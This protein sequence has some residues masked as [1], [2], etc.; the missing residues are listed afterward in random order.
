MLIAGLAPGDL[1]AGRYQL[2][3]PAGED[4]WRGFDQ[5]LQRPVALRP[6]DSGALA[7]AAVAAA[8]HPNLV[9][10]FD[11]AAHHRRRYLVTEL[12][13]GGTLAERLGRGPVPAFEAGE[14]AC[15]VLR[16]VACLHR[17]GLRL[18]RLEPEDVLLGGDGRPQLDAVGLRRARRG[19]GGTAAD[20]VKVGRL[21]ASV[22]I[23]G[24][25]DPVWDY[26]VAGLTARR[27]RSAEEALERLRCPRE[28]AGQ[29]TEEF[30]ALV[31]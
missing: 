22:P 21:L 6:L 20:L 31:V 8:E 2:R 7:D 13:G 1:I 29:D 26:V 4:F 3:E 16:A 12:P 25:S 28:D 10:I 18:D 19:G 30:D 17:A 24:E 9:G 27:I 23:E 15:G 5:R 14:L 11:V